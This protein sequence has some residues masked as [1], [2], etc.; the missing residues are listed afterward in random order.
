MVGTAPGS[1]ATPT[2][3]EAPWR[4]A[5][6]AGRRRARVRPVAFPRRDAAV[7][8][9]DPCLRLRLIPAGSRLKVQP[10]RPG[11]RHQQGEPDPPGNEHRPAVLPDVFADEGVLGDAVQRRGE[12]G[13]R[14]PE[15]RVPRR[16][17]LLL[18]DPGRLT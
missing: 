15:V 12:F 16:E 6:S 4:P 5:S 13:D 2:P 9:G 8:L 10:V 3:G 14:I 1:C 11:G 7:G 18:A 17:L